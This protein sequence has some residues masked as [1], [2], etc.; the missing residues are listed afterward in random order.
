MQTF[1]LICNNN[2]NAYCI[3]INQEKKYHT[4]SKKIN[5]GLLL[6]LVV[7]PKIYPVVSET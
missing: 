1:I 5:F 4:I 2:I 7:Y 6:S 3:S